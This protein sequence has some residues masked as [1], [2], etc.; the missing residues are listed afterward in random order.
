MW[1]AA[2]ATSDTQTALN[3][4]GSKLKG[5]YDQYSGPDPAAIAAVAAKGLTGKVAIIGDDG[6]A[7]EMCDINSGLMAGAQ[8]QPANLYAQ[9]AL[10]TRWTQRRASSSRS[11]SRASALR[12]LPNVSYLNDTNLGDPIVAPFV[13]KTATHVQR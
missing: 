12:R 8:S 2:T 7:Y 5:I 13:T 1:V 4:Y 10:S 6:V 9:G 3:A 11:G